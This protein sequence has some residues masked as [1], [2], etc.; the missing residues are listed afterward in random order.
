[1]AVVPG[2]GRAAVTH[3]TVVEDYGFVQLCRVKLETGRTHQIRVHFTHF[4]H[5]IVGDPV[6][7]DDRR[8]RNIHTLD[9]QPAAMMLR[10]A[11]RQMLHAAALHLRHPSSGRELEFEAPLPPDLAAAVAGLRRTSPGDQTA[12]F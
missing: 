4:H 3:Y 10:V 1:M 6:Y 2:R 9:R 8:V 7:G 11:R 12:H 5:P